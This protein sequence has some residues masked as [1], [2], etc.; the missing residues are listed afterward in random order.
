LSED[1][2]DVDFD[3]GHLWA[4]RLERIDGHVRP[5]CDD[6]PRQIDHVRTQYLPLA[7]QY[8]N[9]MSPGAHSQEIFKVEFLATGC[10]AADHEINA[11]VIRLLADM[12]NSPNVIGFSGDTR[13]VVFQQWEILPQIAPLL[14]AVH[15]EDIGCIYRATRNIVAVET[16]F[17]RLLEL[18]EAAEPFPAQ[19]FPP[20]ET[21]LVEA[22]AENWDV[23]ACGSRV[24]AHLTLA[25]FSHGSIAFRLDLPPY[26]GD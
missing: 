19:A 9:A 12:D 13:T 18:E 16:Q 5:K 15:P 3:F 21:S 25:M 4:D 22:W 24:S 1:G 2:I 7:S 20:G 26:T 23:F 6:Q 10:A 14:L 11:Y 8:S 17:L